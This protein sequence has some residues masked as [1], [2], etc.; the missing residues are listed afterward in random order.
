MVGLLGWNIAQ[1][2]EIASLRNDVV[3][4]EKR[5]FDNKTQQLQ[6]IGGLAQAMTQPPPVAAATPRP[7]RAKA[8]ADGTARA[9]KARTGARTGAAP[10]AKAKARQSEP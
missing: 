10:R 9:G 8:K 4:L 2:R 7:A 6:A 3:A 5:V 1:Q